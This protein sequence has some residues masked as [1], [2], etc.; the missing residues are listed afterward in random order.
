MRRGL[1]ASLALVLMSALAI[2]PVRAVPPAAAGALASSNVD[3]VMN[4][5]DVA[6][7][8][9]RILRGVDTPVLG[10]RD[11][12]Y[13][14]TSQGLRI[15]DVTLGLPVPVGALELPHFE[16]EDV[17]TNGKILLIAADHFLGFP[18][19]LYV[20]NVEN[21][22]APLLVGVLPFPSEAHTV[23]C[24]ND[25]TY[26][27][28]AGGGGLYVVDLR[29]PASPRQVGRVGQEYGGTHDVQVDDK[30]VA[31]VTGGGGLTAYATGDART[32]A[33]YG[34]GT[35][36]APKV[37]ARGRGF[38]NN[39][40]LHNSM[41]PNAA[42]FNPAL[43]SNSVVDPG[44]AVYV[45]EE[46]YITLNE[47]GSFQAGWLRIVGGELTVDF[48]NRWTFANDFA[49]GL[50]HKIAVGFSS[51]HYFDYRDGVMA[52][53]WY[54]QGTR[55]FDVSN[56][57]NIRPIGYFMPAAANETWSAVFNGQY[58]YIIDVGRGIDVLTFS[59]ST[60]SATVTLPNDPSRPALSAPHPEFGACRIRVA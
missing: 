15:Y 4:I 42:A 36:L 38:N 31:W 40:I 58:V 5:P 55:F 8:G 2:S 34:T 30:G 18:N 26:A 44:E 22:H 48:T 41:R 52:V 39:F 37:Y 16:N 43:L 47:D 7:I 1:V 13:V 33:F 3:F 56:V 57:S 12:F 21:P 46:D 17:D 59:G 45:T 27:W 14:T 20:I 50:D 24:I 35:P 53:G 28:L 60:A 25:C 54:E 9:G 49:I 29:N 51:S 19:V 6:A 32:P 10:P 23:T 11:L